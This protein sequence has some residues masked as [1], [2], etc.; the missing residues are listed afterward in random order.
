VNGKTNDKI[1]IIST[2]NNDDDDNK[3]NLYFDNNKHN[4][5]FISPLSIAFLV[6]DIVCE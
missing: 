1:P 2:S 3:K 4:I 6:N 5:K